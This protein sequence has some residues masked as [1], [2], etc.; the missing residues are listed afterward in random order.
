MQNHKQKQSKNKQAKIQK[1][2]TQK[3]S[4][5]M[6]KMDQKNLFFAIKADDEA[7]FC[8]LVKGNENVAFGRFPIL[9]ICYLYHSKKILKKF[10]KEL[11]K[12]NSFVRVDEPFVLLK[13]FHLLAKKVLRLY[14]DE[15]C[16][17]LPIEMLAVLHCDG[18]VQKTFQKAKDKSSQENLQKIYQIF[19]QKVQIKNGK[20]KIFPSSLTTYQKRFFVPFQIASICFAVLFCVVTALCVAGFGAGTKTNPIKIFGA[21]Q[22]QKIGSAGAQTFALQNDISVDDEFC[23]ANFK[24]TIDGG[25]HTLSIN[26]DCQKPLI[27]NLLGTVKNL[28][29]NFGNQTINVDKTTGLLSANNMGTIESVYCTSI[30]LLTQTSEEAQSFGIVAGKNQGEIKNSKVFFYATI[31]N[32][33]ENDAYFAG[34]A[35]ENFGVIENCETMQN[36]QANSQTADL[37]GIAGQNF[38]GAKIKDCKNFASFTQTTDKSGWSPNVAGIA[39]GNVGTIENCFNHGNITATS[40]SLNTSTSVFAGGICAVNNSSILHSQNFADIFAS[41][42]KAQ[43]FVGGICGYSQNS[44]SDQSKLSI[45]E[46]CG[47][48]GHITVQKSSQD[49]PVFCGGIAGFF[50]GKL[51]NCFSVATFGTAFDEQ[52]NFFVGLAVGS[53]FYIYDSWQNQINFYIDPQKIYCLQSAQTELPIA[54]MLTNG[55]YS[56][57]GNFDLGLTILSTKSDVENCE[58]FW[59]E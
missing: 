55:Q 59:N 50:I 44:E 39:D 49:A 23:V 26:F 29:I 38:A 35:G 34:F 51:Q 43:V 54:S 28:K 17:V 52:E 18:K 9:S 4:K 41:S 13:D 10:E 53:V 32:G 11:S 6:K 33:G 37:A 47:A 25:G 27:E 21:E 14:Q 31:Q 40:A 45:V 15:N 1:N 7:C 5:K 58:V 46:N 20:I 36:S 3:G 30:L 56:K 12:I 24:G 22:L 42:K 48:S 57:F 8:N 16:F 19:G 2:A